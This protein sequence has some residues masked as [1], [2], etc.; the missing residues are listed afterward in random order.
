VPEQI[1]V[2]EQFAEAGQQRNADFIGMYVFLGTEIMLFGGLFA[3]ILAYRILHPRSASAASEH[4]YLW[5]GCLNTVVLLTSSLLVA[6]AVLA[7]RGGDAHRL[8]R[9]LLAAAALGA[10]FLG[11][12]ATEYTLEYREGLIPGS[13]PTYDFPEPAQALFINL[14]LVSTGLHAF[15]LVIGILALLW[16]A[17]R[18]WIRQARVPERTVTVEMLGLY[19][20]L[21]DVIWVFLFPVLYLARG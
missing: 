5:L 2:R 19:W 10:V 8:L 17:Y 3:V 12:K 7:A 9:R 13:G 11:V 18:L 20:H 21:V 1:T 4:L 6:L 15:H 16:F 14:Y